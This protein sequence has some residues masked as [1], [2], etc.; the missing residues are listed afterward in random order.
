MPA[1]ELIL[2]ITLRDIRPPIWRR[3]RVADDSSLRKLHQ[4]IQVAMGWQDAHLHE[5]QVGNQVYGEPSDHDGWPGGSRTQNETKV[6]LASLVAQGVRRFRYVYDFGDGWE[7]EVVIEKVQPLDPDQ[8]YPSL[9][10]GK[11]ACPPEDCGGPYGYPQLLEVLADPS[12]EEHAEMTEW[13]GGDFD[14][15]HLDL[16]AVNHALAAMARRG[17]A[18]RPKA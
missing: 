3:V 15:E 13:V 12:D 9:I 5:F 11:R 2:K 18:R 16:E 7:H 17:R 1:N 6:K 4:V 10:T 14:P 8:Q